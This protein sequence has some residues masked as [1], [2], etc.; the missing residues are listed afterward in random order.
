MVVGN[1]LIDLFGKSPVRPIQEH[2]QKVQSGTLILLKFVRAA[3]KGDWKEA[4][5]LQ[6]EI[7]AR[8]READKLKHSVRTH[9]PKRLF[10]PVSRGDLIELVTTQDRIINR[11]KDVAGLMLGRKIRFPKVIFPL[12]RDYIKE[13]IGVSAATLRAIETLDKVFEAGFGR[14]E[15]RQVDALIKEIGKL[16]K[17]TDKQQIKI[18]AEL[19]K[20][21]ESLP[22]VDVMF[23]YTIIEL[24]GDIADYAERASNRLQILIST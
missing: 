16:E 9:L 19:F 8:E 24:I 13:C 5:S 10:M 22:P 7:V 15:V 23:L 4:E 17:R 20:I 21:E 11:T 2:M 14:R 18:R 1:P 12:V 3:Q 6:K